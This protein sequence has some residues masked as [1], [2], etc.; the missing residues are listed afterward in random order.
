[1]SKG[2]PQPE[3]PIDQ[4]TGL[5][6]ILA[7]GRADRPDAFDALAPEPRANATQSCPFCEGREDRTPPP[8]KLVRGSDP[9]SAHPGDN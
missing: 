9:R 6:A 4:L 1:M 2:S 3:I 7:P 8:A 5:R